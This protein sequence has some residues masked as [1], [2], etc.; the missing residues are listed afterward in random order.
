M[1]LRVCKR[2]ACAAVLLVRTQSVAQPVMLNTD[3][4]C[5]TWFLGTALHCSPCVGQQQDHGCSELQNGR[6]T[7]RFHGH[8]RPADPYVQRASRE[9]QEAAARR[10]SALEGLKHTRRARHTLNASWALKD[11]GVL[12]YACRCHATCDMYRAHGLSSCAHLQSAH[13]TKVAL[14]L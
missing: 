14:D 4:L 13:V 12:M 6:A 9:Q 7:P 1:T 10:L 2:A 3:T 11:Y 5:C 8:Q